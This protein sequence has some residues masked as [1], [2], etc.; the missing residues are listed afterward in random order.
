MD[1]ENSDSKASL[2]K[3]AEDLAASK[4]T[5]GHPIS[6]ADND[7]LLHELEVHQIELEIQNQELRRAQQQLQLSR[8]R[9]SDLFEF[10]PVGYF[11]LDRHLHIVEANLT[12]SRLLDVKRR[13]LHGKRFSGF[14]AKEHQDALYQFFRAGAD[15]GRRICKVE[16]IRPDG[17]RFVA[18]LRILEKSD[19]E[20]YAVYRV[21]IYDITE[22]RRAEEA[23][24]QNERRFRALTEKSG[25]FTGILDDKGNIVHAIIG[26]T[27]KLLYNPQDLIGRNAFELVHPEDVPGASELFQ[28]IA[29]RPK[30]VGEIV[31][32]V[33]AK[34]GTWRWMSFVGTNLLEESFVDGIV[35]NGRD[36]TDK[37][38]DEEEL[39]QSRQDLARAQEIGQI[40]SWHLDIRRNILT[41]S[42]EHYR[43]FGV[44]KGTPLCYETFLDIVHPDDRVYVAK[45][46]E[47]A[48]RGEPYDIEFRIVTNDQVK[49]LRGKAFVQF[50]DEGKPLSAIGIAQN[51]TDRKKMEEKLRQS[52]DELELRVQERTRELS[53]AVHSLEEHSH[54]LR[55]MSAELTIAEQRE[56]RR[57][58]QILHDGLQQILVGA[59]LQLE[60][61]AGNKGMTDDMVRLRDI[62]D[63]AI[64]TSRSLAVE[65][66]PPILL[67]NDLCA[68]LNWLADLMQEKYGLEVSMTVCESRQPLDQ[69]VLFLIFQAARELLLNVIKHAGVRKAHMELKRRDGQILLIVEDKGVGFNPALLD[70]KRGGSRGFGLFSLR[71]RLS[72]LGGK[73]E[74]DSAPGRGSRFELVAPV[75]VI[76]K[77]TDRLS[78]VRKPS[79]EEDVF[80]GL[81]S[82][83]VDSDIQIRIMLVDDH[84]VVRQGV[85]NLMRRESDFEIVGQAADGKSAVELVGE[86]RPDVVLMDI[87]MPVMDGIEATR[88]IHERF[89]GIRIVGFSVY[90]EE[91]QKA[92][93]IDAGAVAYWTKR[94]PLKGLIETIRAC[95]REVPS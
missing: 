35:I 24:E 20:D 6:A 15:K 85:A 52:N 90:E 75:S 61:I 1:D 12:G 22:R 11:T 49:W 84:A 34:D 57:L 60:F 91:S 64:D 39:R 38:K 69:E 50:E 25:E 16:M 32:R 3:K 68:A 4:K 30:G 7:A 18:E 72:L 41:W 67:R 31:I 83:K 74:I 2:R 37:K 93:I 45:Q 87:N 10:A 40:G 21:A 94:Q 14:V 19:A 29:R 42:E 51:I 27:S 23:L 65:L 28:D 76:K 43:I 17:T 55:R 80:D 46:W 56:R 8:D 63:E 47:A 78:V 36:I 86:I 59:I 33:R 62:L 26:E 54:Q 88:I 92:A 89:E 53:N 81:Q 9:Y 58:A 95:V 77:E 5:E 44:A 48:M 13:V 79:L 70:T 71:E 66:S 82:A 73:L